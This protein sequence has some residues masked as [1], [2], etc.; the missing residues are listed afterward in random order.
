MKSEFDV[1]NTGTIHDMIPEGGALVRSLWGTR[2]VRGWLVPILAF[3]P[4]DWSLE[5]IYYILENLFLMRRKR[6][7]STPKTAAA[8]AKEA[9][10]E[11]NETP[12]FPW[13]L[14]AVELTAPPTS[15]I[16]VG[17]G[18]ALIVGIWQSCR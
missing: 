15:E 10:N 13:A 9:R 5:E 11:F 16:D 3:G 2:Y 17:V 14:P 8:T 12:A 7:N 1:R 18:A 4:G 6:R